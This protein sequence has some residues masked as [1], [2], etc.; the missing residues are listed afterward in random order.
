MSEHVPEIFG[1]C[2][3]SPIELGCE[4]GWRQYDPLTWSEHVAVDSLDAAW[5][6][7]EAALPEGWAFELTY[8]EGNPVQS[9]AWLPGVEIVTGDDGIRAEGSTPAAALRALAAKLREVGR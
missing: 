7:A 5:A 2:G 1:Y 6:E 3:E 8:S 4:C 9:W